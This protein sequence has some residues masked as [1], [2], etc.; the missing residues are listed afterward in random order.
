M[1]VHS[2]IR[3]FIQSK[4]AAI[5]NRVWL[6][7]IYNLERHFERCATLIPSNLDPDLIGWNNPIVPCELLKSMCT[8][9][10]EF[11]MYLVNGSYFII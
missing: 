8:K 10:N 5:A 2:R 1:E 11:Y 4:D 3:C 7:Y 9:K 6:F